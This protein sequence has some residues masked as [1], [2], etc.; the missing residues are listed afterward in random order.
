MGVGD[1]Q[2]SIRFSEI[3]FEGSV[4]TRSQALAFDKVCEH[5]T[6]NSFGR[7][8]RSCSAAN[9]TNGATSMSLADSPSAISDPTRLHDE[10]RTRWKRKHVCLL[11]FMPRGFL[12]LGDVMLTQK[13]ALELFASEA[14]TIANAT[15]PKTA[16]RL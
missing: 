3:L 16:L 9:T 10:R 12:P 6:W 15:I 1:G 5:A 4:A 13:M 7:T 14:I 2:V 8:F 11:C